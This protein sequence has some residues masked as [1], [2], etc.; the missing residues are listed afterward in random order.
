MNR[1]ARYLARIGFTGHPRADFAT[2]EAIIPLHLAAIPFEA[3]DVT[4]GNPPGLDPAA[5]FNKLVE[6][7]R[8]G[9][10]Y[11]QNG[12]LGEMLRSIGFDVTRISSAVMRKKRSDSKLESHLALRVELDRSYLVDVGFGGTLSRPL[13]IEEGEWQD[14]PY[15]I[16]LAKLP[17]GFWR[18]SEWLGQ[19]DPFSY[20]FLTEQ[21]DEEA[22]ARTSAWLGS[23][24]TSNFVGNLVAQR[25]IGNTHL[26]LRGKVLSEVGLSGTA[27]RE[28][29]DANDLVA[30]LRDRFG[31]DLP[32]I[33]T[34]WPAVEAR[35]AK[36]FPPG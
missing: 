11:E 7:S 31:L 21:A 8:G 19:G 32:E 5:H 25:R 29:V 22:L 27:R 20:D 18:F 33:A 28:L 9:W 2:L 24:P 13:P 12:L 36:L 16:A 3:L 10:C 6:R 30:T 17:D 1:L 26:V 23:D 14:G 34:R 4:L 35:H 15:R